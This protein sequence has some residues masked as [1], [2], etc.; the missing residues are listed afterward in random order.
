MSHFVRLILFILSIFR[1]GFICDGLMLQNHLLYGLCR[2]A[3]IY[4]GLNKH[5]FVDGK[6]CDITEALLI[7]Y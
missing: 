7:D 6:R 4:N 5:S 3:K 1:S 2:V